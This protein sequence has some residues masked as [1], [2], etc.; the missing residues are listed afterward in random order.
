MKY[1]DGR[2]KALVEIS[3]MITATDNFF[4]IKDKI[5][6]KMLEVIFSV[7][8]CVNLFINDYKYTHLVCSSTLNYIPKFFEKNKKNQYHLPF[9]SYPIYIH[10]AVQEKKVVWIKDVH[11]DERTKDERLIAQNEGYKSMAI[12]PL[13]SNNEVIGFMICFFIEDSINYTDN[14]IDFISSI[15]SLIGLSVEITRKKKRF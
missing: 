12:F 15:A 7:K 3:T 4:D 11:N 10:D 8:A 9:E 13:I 5:I 14:D 1:T 6:E 2:I